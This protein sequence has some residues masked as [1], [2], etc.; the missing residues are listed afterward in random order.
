MGRTGGAGTA[1]P[2]VLG[3]CASFQVG[4]ALATRLFPV[5]GP[6]GTT[7]LR[8][9][10][11]AA[12][13]L[14]VVRPRVRGWQRA[15]WRSVLLYGVSLAGMNGFYYAALARLPLSAAVTIQFLGPLTLSAALSRRWRDAAWVVLAL[16]GV[17]TLGLADR[18]GGGTGAGL[19]P[20]GAGFAL[21]SACFWAL[22]IL[23]GSRASAAVPGRGGLAVAMTAGAVA[24]APFGALGAGHAVARPFPVLLA[25][26]VAVMAS[27]V[28]Y[29]LEL[30]AMRRAPRRV[31]G[32]LLS[33]DP[34][35]ATLA[36]WVLLGQSATPLAVAA[37]ATVI[38]AR[39]GSTL[40]AGEAA[41][42]APGNAGQRPR[43]LEMR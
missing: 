21:V 2:L 18:H 25:A 11:A 10:I 19:D 9:A 22:Y 41:V 38:T 20:V 7:L 28:P 5:A 33:L 40:A 8:L 23:A 39:A 27:V 34:A 4:A 17:F 29:S 42:P 36:G 13:L 26:G 30:A 6:W 12:V 37:V 3:S 1:V 43:E 14:A 15:Q 31:F 32:I 16:L 24:L 35:L